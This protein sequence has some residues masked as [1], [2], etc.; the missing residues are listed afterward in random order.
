ME[1]DVHYKHRENMWVDGRMGKL[2][3]DLNY[4]NKFI[5]HKSV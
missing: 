2:I 4:L 5:K 3:L 1:F